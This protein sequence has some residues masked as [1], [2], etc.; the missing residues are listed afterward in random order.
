MLRG[1]YYYRQASVVRRPSCVVCRLLTF[2]NIF[3]SETTGPIS[4]KFDVNDPWVK[5][6]Q[7]I[8]FYWP[9]SVRGGV[10]PR[11]LFHRVTIGKTS[12]IFFSETTGPIWKKFDVNDPWV[13]VSQNIVFYWP[14][15]IRGG[16]KPRPLFHWITIGKTSNIFFSETTGQIWK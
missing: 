7:N 13:E 12:N 4:T 5:V 16:V 9:S 3:F 10:R 8:V 1:S 11:P 15:L 2:S 6:S 14:S